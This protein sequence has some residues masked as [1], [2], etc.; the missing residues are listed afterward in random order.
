MTTMISSTTQGFFAWR[1]ARLTG[2]NWMGYLIG[3]SAFIQL[4]A[5]L[6]STIGASM[7]VDFDRFQ[8]LKAAVITWL[9]LSAITDIAITCVL[10]WHLVSLG[11]LMDRCRLTA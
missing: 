4:A 1:I 10:S 6:G 7:V 2:H 3:F 9:G 11:N 5:G 8:E